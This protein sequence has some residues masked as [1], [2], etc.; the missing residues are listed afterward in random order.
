MCKRE[1]GDILDRN[2][3]SKLI[4][5]YF[6][7]WIKQ[8]LELFSKVVHEKAVIRECTGAVMEGK[9]ELAS[10]FTQWNN[11]DNRV[12][13]WGIKEIEFDEVS[14][15]A[16]VEWIFKCFYEA[17]D[18]EWDGVSVVRFKEALIIELNEYEMKRD[19]FFPYRSSFI[20]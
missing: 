1:M 11:G 7:S 13:Y 20:F 8:D 18:Y 17:K 2:Q 19:K 3:A 9:A 5:Q 12:D 14:Q 15:V 10:W 16:F 6:E 4:D